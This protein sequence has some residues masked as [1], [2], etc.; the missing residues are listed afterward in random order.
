[1]TPAIGYMRL[2]KRLR[3]ALQAMSSDWA[4]GHARIHASF[5]FSVVGVSLLFL[6]TGLLGSSPRE[7]ISAAITLP[8]VWVLSVVV[9]VAA[10]QLALGRFA[11]DILCVIGPTGNFAIDYEY[12]PRPR[13]VA[14]AVSGQV[15]SLGLVGIGWLVSVATL[16][17]DAQAVSWVQL[18]DFRGG[19]S[20]YAFGTQIVWV[21]VF[22]AVLH[23]LPT[24]PFDMRALV[25]ATLTF[26]GQ[27][28]VEPRFL[29][30][31]SSLDSHLSAVCLG[32][33]AALW[34]GAATGSSDGLGWYAFIAAAIYL[35]VGAQWEA[36]RA[37][38]LEQQYAPLAAHHHPFSR[39]EPQQK[40]KGPHFKLKRIRPVEPEQ[41]DA[42]A[43]DLAR[44]ASDFAVDIPGSAEITEVSGSA[45]HAG[46]SVDKTVDI[47]EILRKVHREGT[48]A[49]SDTEHQALL[50]ASRLLNA[51]RSSAE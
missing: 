1:M 25:F 15:A 20:N 19:F 9:R 22:L 10:Q 49:L 34:V 33:G 43:E 11:G 8:L 29:R 4:V 37:T 6:G 51:R 45:N 21:N 17:G 31:L 35:Y 44:H 48:E 3:I 14:Y 50:S 28:P 32:I 47:D 26:R 2:L 36:S 41:A 7:L 12:L 16:P 27:S 38:E 24:V 46:M 40:L 42:A 30:T 39:P 5:V 23:T 18:M 13:L